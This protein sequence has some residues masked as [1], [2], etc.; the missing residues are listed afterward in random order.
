MKTILNIISSPGK[1]ASAS[2][3]VADS[4]IEKLQE[5]HPGSSVIVRDLSANPLPHLDATLLASFFSPAETHS[6]AQKAAIANSDQAIAE[7]KEADVIVIGVPMYN[8]GIP[9]TLKAWIDHIFRAG[10]TFSYGPDGPVGLLGDK[11]IY[12]SIASGGKYSEGAMAQY[13]FTDPYLRK[14]LGFIGLTDITTFRAEG[15]KM[16]DGDKVVENVVDSMV[17]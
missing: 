5:E 1:G 4:I 7:V 17:L 12:L 16:A 3:R 2:I 8:F 15:L 10:V 6:D 9:S 11:K 14:A 13:D